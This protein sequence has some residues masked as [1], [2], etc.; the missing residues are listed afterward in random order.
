MGGGGGGGVGSLNCIAYSIWE[1]CL[2]FDCSI[3]AF[4]VPGVENVRADRLSRKHER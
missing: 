1:L 2:S 3:E 4:H